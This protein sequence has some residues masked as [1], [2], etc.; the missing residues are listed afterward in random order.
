MRGPIASLLLGVVA[1]AGTAAESA[2]QVNFSGSAYVCFDDA[3]YDCNPNPNLLGGFGGSWSRVNPAPQLGFLGYDFNVTTNANTGE[4]ALNAGEGRFFDGSFTGTFYLALLFLNAPVPATTLVFS[5]TATTLGDLLLVDFQ[6]NLQNGTY[7]PSGSPFFGE[8]NDFALRRGADAS[9]LI[10]GRLGVTPTT[11]V[12]EPS[13]LLLLGVG[14]AVLTVGS[15]RR[16][17]RAA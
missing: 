5:G 7:G 2:A 13:T 1:L 15:A 10:T 9:T 8:L 17:R 4:V 12:P 16:A 3:L 6:P 11:V 14:L